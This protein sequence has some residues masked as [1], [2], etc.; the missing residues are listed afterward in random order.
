MSFKGQGH[1][2]DVLNVKMSVSHYQCSN[3]L[4]GEAHVIA[5]VLRKTNILG[6]HLAEVGRIKFENKMMTRQTLDV[7]W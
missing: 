1:A 2:Y 3:I 4:T 7:S 6:I 5:L